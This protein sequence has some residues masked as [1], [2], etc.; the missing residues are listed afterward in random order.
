[1]E[2]TVRAGPLDGGKVRS[3]QGPIARKAPPAET[4][5]HLF[6]LITNHTL[7]IY[8]VLARQTFL[9]LK[10]TNRV[11]ATDFFAF[12]F[13]LPKSLLFAQVFVFESKSTS[14]ERSF[15]TTSSKGRVGSLRFPTKYQLLL[16]I[17]F[18]HSSLPENSLFVYLLGM[19]SSHKCKI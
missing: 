8:Y 18:C 9:F 15:L 1:M 14:L 5:D 16:F 17:I 13:L 3:K 4:P 11:P 6:S 12:V 10:P 19:P 2:V 7:L